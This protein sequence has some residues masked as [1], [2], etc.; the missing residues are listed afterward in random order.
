MI[1]RYGKLVAIAL[2]VMAVLWGFGLGYWRVTINNSISALET[3]AKPTT[4]AGESETVV[5]E[6]WDEFRSSGDRA[7]PFIVE[8]LKT[9]HNPAFLAALSRHFI[10]RASRLIPMET[11]EDLR[12]I[13]ADR[14][15]EI[16]RKCADIRN[17]WTRMEPR[18]RWWMWW[19]DE[20]LE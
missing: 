19:T 11:I 6:V 3:A 15:E 1:N 14:A 7:L 5:K 9:N 10:D 2:G 12:I 20:G 18:Y 4:A 8:S 13:P 17:L 16:E